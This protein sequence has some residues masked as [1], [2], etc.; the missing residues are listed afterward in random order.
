MLACVGNSAEVRA[1]DST[2]P[3]P[4]RGFWVTVVMV[5]RA[6]AIN[7]LVRVVYLAVIY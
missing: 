6:A 7:F 5:T 3:K 4:E 1:N 2:A